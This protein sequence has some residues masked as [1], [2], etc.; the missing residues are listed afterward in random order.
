MFVGSAPY[1]PPLSKFISGVNVSCCHSS[2]ERAVS[3]RRFRNASRLSRPVLERAQVGGSSLL[4]QYGCSH[5][6]VIS[7]I[8]SRFNLGRRMLHRGRGYHEIVPI[9]RLV[10]IW[11]FQ[12]SGNMS[13]P[14][15]KVELVA[16]N[17]C[18]EVSGVLVTLGV[19]IRTG[20]FP[21]VGRSSKS[22][23]PKMSPSGQVWSGMEDR[24][25]FG[26]WKLS[27]S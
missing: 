11:F 18:V 12:G 16:G 21:V 25:L 24:V 2:S 15:A 22:S 26:V 13:G 20:V 10:K 5:S 3:V 17:G 27:S 4:V 8:R 19:R 9:I 14:E 7:Y 6:S 1:K 23:P